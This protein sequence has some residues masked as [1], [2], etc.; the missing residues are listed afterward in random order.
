MRQNIA[1]FVALFL[2]LA[3]GLW[4]Q[5]DLSPA[6]FRLD[7]SSVLYEVVMLFGLE[8]DWTLNVTLPWQLEFARILAPL[9]SVAGLL[10]LLTRGAWVGVTNTFIRFWR[11][12]II[13]VGLSE[14][15]LQFVQT[16]Q[17]AHRVVVLERNPDNPW[18]ERLRND[19][20]SVVVGDALVDE[21]LRAVSAVSAKHLVTFCG[22]DGDSVEIALTVREYLTKQQQSVGNRLRIHLHVN[23]TRISSLLEHY[24]KFY[25]DQQVAE[26]DFFSEFELTARILLRNY[27]PDRFAQYF[28][29]SQVHIAVFGFDTLGKHILIEAVRMCHFMNG[30]K[31]RFSIFDNNV[32]QKTQELMSLHPNIETLCQ[33][34]QIEMPYLLPLQLDAI[35]S[36]LLCTVTE[37]VI[38]LP[39]DDQN[40]E[41]AL[42]L[43]AILIERQGCNAPIN[44]RVQRSTGLAKL[45][46]ATENEPEIPDGIFPFGMLDE[47]LFYENVLGDRMD[48]LAQAMHEEYLA[49]RSNISS[50]DRL[51]SSLKSWQS[52]PEPQR[53]SSRLQA[54]HLAAKLRAINCRFTTSEDEFF[55]FTRAEAEIL[56][57]MEHN[58]WRANATYEGWKH[59][60]VRID[61]AKINPYNIPWEEMEAS[62]QD[63]QIGAIFALPEM[64]R[65]RLGLGI[66]REFYIGVTGHRADKL[67]RQEVDETDIKQVL[68]QIVGQ[69]PERKIVLVSPLAEGVD[70]MFAKIALDQM[71]L[72]LHVSLPLP[73]ELYQTDFSSDESLQEF[74]TLVGRA[75]NYYEMPTRFGNVETL[76]SH[77]SGE[78]NEARNHQYALADAYIAQTCDELVAI[79]DGNADHGKGSKE[80]MVKQ[81]QGGIPSQYQFPA[82]FSVRPKPL[83]VRAIHAEKS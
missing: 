63:A 38:C 4:G 21:S 32:A 35:S 39:R 48:E 6:R 70:R 45:L 58:R 7:F 76:A 3:L 51:N 44:V 18:I 19:G 52:L 9:V 54:D 11:D 46:E 40:L 62:E 78:S 37:H 30:S 22:N 8:G 5:Y 36:E 66:Q 33:I 55:K 17:G 67:D 14:R 50:N 43:R 68:E 25:T 15:G 28:G 20:V 74:K 59:G 53:K 34:D 64:L 31:L 42:M 60:S 77:I 27:P 82:D 23:A 13:V 69:H 2:V 1:I 73:Y 24:A 57:R 47:I 29:Q 79:Y 71:G 49:R 83:P 12:H 10:I 65:S 16:C 80:Q 75:E 41:L 72:V 61:G 56:A 81:R 26:V